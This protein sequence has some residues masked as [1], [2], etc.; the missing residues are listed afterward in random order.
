MEQRSSWPT[1]QSNLLLCIRDAKDHGAWERFVDLYAPV[2]FRYCRIQGLQE[3][4]AQDVTQEVLSQISR[5]IGNFEY[6]PEKGKFRSWLGTVTWHRI[7]RHRRARARQVADARVV[8][9]ILSEIPGKD[10]GAWVE[11]FNSHILATALKN[12]RARCSEEK[13]QAFHLLWVES[14]PPTD[15]AQQLD[16]RIEWVYKTKSRVLKELKREVEFLA[17]DVGAL[18]N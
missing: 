10:D 12:V 15:V 13:W 2:I 4:D 16:R 3:A 7:C 17:A 8:G 5:S 1:T 14:L 11:V 18:S 9:E 6:D